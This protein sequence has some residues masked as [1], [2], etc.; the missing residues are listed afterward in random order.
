MGIQGSNVLQDLKKYLEEKTASLDC[1]AVFC[2]YGIYAYVLLG[3][4]SV[5]SS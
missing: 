2:E 1:A 4:W 5:H 3:I